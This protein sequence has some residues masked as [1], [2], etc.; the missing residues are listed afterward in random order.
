MILSTIVLQYFRNFQ[1]Q[2]FTFNPSL[3][4]IIGENARGKT[5]LLESIYFTIYGTGF[6]ESREEELVNWE[7]ERAVVQSL[8][9]QSEHKHMFQ[10]ML[11]RQAETVAKKFFVNKTAKTHYSYLQNQTRAV[12][13][14]PEHIEII[15]GSPEERREYF[16]KVISAYDLE[17][18][19]KLNNYRTALRKRNKVLETYRDEFSL[20]EQIS[21][22]NDYLEEQGK[23][24]TQKRQEY[25]NYLN[26]HPNIQNRIFRIEYVKNEFTKERLRAVY[27]LETKIRKTRIG[28]QKDDFMIYLDDIERKNVQHFGSRSEQRLAI[29]WLKLNEIS[30]FEQFFKSKPIL[31]LDDVFSELDNKNKK[32]VLDVITGYQ[33]VL[34]TTEEELVELSAEE[35]T[36]IRI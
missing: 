10:I 2:T 8:F 20:L 6:R 21:F 22:W 16:D 12:L 32:L 36:L 9:L 26:A 14:A 31:L 33:T 24:I 4:I 5:S 28:P 15:T 29:F 1:Q 7:Q 23:Y 34:T 3:T 13:F 11:Q 19:K 27:D 17:Y 30:F 35:K 25:T 18:K